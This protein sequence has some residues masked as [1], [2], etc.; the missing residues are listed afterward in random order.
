MMAYLDWN[1]KLVNNK[2]SVLEW[3]MELFLIQA[4]LLSQKN[5]DT[6]IRAWTYCGLTEWSVPKHPVWF[7]WYA[8]MYSRTSLRNSGA[9]HRPPSG[10][11]YRLV[12][13]P[14]V[15]GAEKEARRKKCC[16]RYCRVTWERGW[17]WAGSR[18]LSAREQKWRWKQDERKKGKGNRGG[19]NRSV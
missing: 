10:I 1:M 9:V 4:L 8:H 18:N 7:W 19:R 16:W 17:L 2:T 6:N 3:T 13:L 12:L 14:F 11:G 15:R 5:V